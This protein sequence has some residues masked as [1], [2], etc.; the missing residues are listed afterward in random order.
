MNDDS[1]VHVASLTDD[2]P[3]STPTDDE[4]T[5]PSS[6]PRRLELDDKSKGSPPPEPSRGA[7]D[8]L[9]EREDGDVPGSSLSD[10]DQ[11]MDKVYGDHVH[12]NPG[13]HL[14]G[15]I[16]DDA[17]WQERWLQ[18]AS[19]PSH[20]YDVP[21]GAVGKR[22]VERVAEELKGIRSRKWN[23]ERFL[24]LQVVILQRS[25]DVK[26]SRDVRQ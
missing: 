22:F 2:T 9:H 19:F 23:S 8:T 3:Q 15:G 18:L 21:S 26:R 25:R 16:A 20:A 11:K 12:Q 1:P 4:P 13:K 6:E 14:T 7:A 10:A 24:V 17:L 5:S